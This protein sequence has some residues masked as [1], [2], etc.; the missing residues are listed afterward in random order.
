MI[1]RD[2]TGGAFP[3]RRCVR[4]EWRRAGVVRDLE[5]H[6]R[7]SR[8]LQAGTIDVAIAL[9]PAASEAGDPWPDRDQIGKRRHFRHPAQS[10]TDP[11]AGND[12]D[13]SAIPV[14]VLGGGMAV[15]PGYL[16]SER[17]T[18]PSGPL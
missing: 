1:V 14:V 5:R 2:D 12:L 8:L 7:L 10:D 4:S 3:R 9:R 15:E 16:T 17:P 18:Q 11:S 13:S 6:R